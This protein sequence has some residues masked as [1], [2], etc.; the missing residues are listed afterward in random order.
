[1]IHGISVPAGH[2]DTAY[3]DALFQNQLDPAV[4]MDFEAIYQLKVS[5]HLLI[6]RAGELTQY[7]SLLDRAWHAGES[8][9]ESR[10]NCNDFSIGIELVGTDDQPYTQA[11]YQALAYWIAQIQLRWP[12][13]EADRIVAHS[14][15]APGRKTDPGPSF[16]WGLL[17]EK[18]HIVF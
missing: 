14:D 13:I 1:M 12:T 7:V 11:Q 5:A 15:I 9:F 18:L 2:W 6:D 17:R 3:I 4:H 16:D 8:Q 10:T